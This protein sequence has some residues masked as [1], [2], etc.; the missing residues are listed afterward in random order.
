MSPLDGRAAVE[1]C[2]ERLRDCG[3]H[4]GDVC[5]AES[6]SLEARV[7]GAEIDFVKQARERTLGIRAFVAGH[8]G[9][10]AASASK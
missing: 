4:S 3:A 5:F 6:D 7:R 10:A 1:R 9:Q 8:G 2:L